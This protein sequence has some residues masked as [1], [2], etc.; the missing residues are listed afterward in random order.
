MTLGFIFLPFNPPGWWNVFP[1]HQVRSLFPGLSTSS[2]CGGLN[3]SWQCSLPLQKAK[4]RQF[5][6]MMVSSR[7]WGL[8]A[9]TK[10]SLLWHDLFLYGKCLSLVP[11]LAACRCFISASSE[12]QKSANSASLKRLI[13]GCISHRRW[14]IRPQEMWFRVSGVNPDSSFCATPEWSW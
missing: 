8:S 13:A 4:F 5:I 7:T 6:L 2:I 10:Q 11:F 12:K 3:L 14:C 1:A 9:V